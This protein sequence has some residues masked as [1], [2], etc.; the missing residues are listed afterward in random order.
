MKMSGSSCR[1]L[2]YQAQPVAIYFLDLMKRLCHNRKKGLNL[3]IGQAPRPAPTK[4]LTAYVGVNL[5][6]TRNCDTVSESNH[7]KRFF[8]G[9]FHS[10]SGKNNEMR[11]S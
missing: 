8:L 4:D 1:G 6:F 2:I 11:Q 5:V 7:Y 3:E 10:N 9:H